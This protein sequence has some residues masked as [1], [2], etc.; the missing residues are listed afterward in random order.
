VAEISAQLIGATPT[1][2]YLEYA[3]WWNP[4]LEEP[5]RVKNGMAI[6]GRH[7][8]NGIS[9]NEQAVAQLLV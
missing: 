1:A 8:R 9:W 3:D 4:V 2:H 5:L 7:D 6:G